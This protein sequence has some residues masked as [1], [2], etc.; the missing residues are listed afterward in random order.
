[1]RLISTIKL[2]EKLGVHRT[3]VWRLRRETPG[4]PR[5]I[6]LGYRSVVWNDDEVDAWL[7]SRHQPQGE[8]RE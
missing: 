6:K 8:S 7:L 1:M 2:A 4:F 5:P 3:T